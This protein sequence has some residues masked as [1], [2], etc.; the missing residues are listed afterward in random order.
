MQRALLLLLIAVSYILFAGGPRWTLVPLALLTGAAILV[1]PKRTLAFPFEGR[2]LDLSLA[3]LVAA[4]A[5][6]LAPLPQ[7][8]VSLMSPHAADLRASLQFRTFTDSAW[9]RLSVDP[10]RTQDALA[11]VVLAIAAFWIARGVFSFGG[12]TRHF[13]RALALVG[14]A[15]ALSAIIFRATAPGLVN[16][17]LQP[18]A[19]SANPFGAFINRNHLAGWLLLVAGPVCGYLIAHLRT[20]PAYRQ[21]FGIGL[22]Q[23][24]ASGAMVTALAAM[25]IV[26]MLLL[27]LSRSG[28]AGLGAAAIF[29][30]RVGRQRLR[31]ERTNLPVILAIAGI[32]LL[33]AVLFVD[34]AGWTTRIEESF[35]TSND[36]NRITIWRESLPIV[37]DFWFSGT[38]AGTFGDAMIKY[39]QSR[40][41]VGSMNR[42][43][44]FNTAHS[45]YVQ[46]I[47]EGGL[48]VFVPVI[49][50]LASLI[51]LGRRAVRED[52][53][54]MQWARIGAGAALIG[55]GV[56]SIWETS[57]VMPANA[58]LCGVVAGLLVYQR[59]KAM[60]RVEPST[61]QLRPR[62]AAR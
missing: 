42:W 20:H 43:A 27:T 48:M 13:R 55:I 14:A 45:H 5:V 37:R 47:V 21:R 59:P 3:G 11:I 58:I 31:I 44:H 41:W 29:G 17:I 26:G 23:F 4:L 54:E 56:Q 35:D 50:A 51:A 28:A 7:S 19:R 18:E 1:A 52:R 46:L 53:G 30:W 33:A 12:S 9:V 24:L 10:A 62:G 15:A 49:A 60:G 25:V 57:L 40:V 34:M 8:I 2:A 32:G 61:D 39:Q 16:G 36:R 6:Q 22:K 38:G